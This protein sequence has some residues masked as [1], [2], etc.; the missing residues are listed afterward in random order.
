M[1]SI[2]GFGVGIAVLGAAACSSSTSV[3]G[4]C[5]GSGA[6]ATVSATDGLVFSPASVPITHGQSVCW[7][8]TGTIAHTVTSNDNGT[9]FNSNL[10]AGQTFLHGFASVSSDSPTSAAGRMFV[11]TFA[12]P[13]SFPYHCTVHPSMTGAI[14]VN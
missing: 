3:A 13:G 11:I 6:A 5:S 2:L 12:A 7:Q 4:A 10:A 1:R 14:T 9:S 8:N